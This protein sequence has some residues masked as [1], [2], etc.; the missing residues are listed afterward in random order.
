MPIPGVADDKPAAKALMLRGTR[1]AL[2]NT[3]ILYNSNQFA[4]L[5]I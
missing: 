2:S 4:L 3:G 1:G 5:P